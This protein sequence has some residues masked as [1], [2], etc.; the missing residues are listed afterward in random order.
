MAEL[1]G[2]IGL[3][4]QHVGGLPGVAYYLPGGRRVAKDGELVLHDSNFAE[5]DS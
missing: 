1:V 4:Q 2:T 3:F 5:S